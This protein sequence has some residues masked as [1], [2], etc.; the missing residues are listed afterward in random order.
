[1]KDKMVCF[2]ADP[3]TLEEARKI[4]VGEGKTLSGVLNSYLSEI[5][6][7]GSIA[8][9]SIPD[10]PNCAESTYPIGYFSFLKGLN[11]GEFAGFDLLAPDE[12][13]EDVN[14]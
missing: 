9:S 12:A 1:M 3:I 7:H 5:A 2:R 14:L 6:R 4:I 13:P 10:R 11:N 8:L